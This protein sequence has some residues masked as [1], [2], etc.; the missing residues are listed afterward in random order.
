MTDIP[1]QERGTT[2]EARATS[3]LPYRARIVAAPSLEERLKQE[4]AA[5]AQ[6]W[7]M[8]V[9]P[10]VDRSQYKYRM[11]GVLNRLL[12][13]NQAVWLIKQLADQQGFVAPN[14]KQVARIVRLKFVWELPKNGHDEADGLFR[15]NEPGQ[16]EYEVFIKYS[17]QLQFEEFRRISRGIESYGVWP[18]EGKTCSYMYYHRQLESALAHTLFH[19]L[20]HVW[21]IHEFADE[22]VAYPTGHGDVRTCEIDYDNFLSHLKAHSSELDALEGARPGI[23]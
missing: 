11:L 7:R 16:P 10:T 19:E 6:R 4:R 1:D 13:T 3:V 5:A 2:D 12:E 15:P 8:F 9:K 14:G 21:Y 17:T 20:L 18:D 23:R 22:P